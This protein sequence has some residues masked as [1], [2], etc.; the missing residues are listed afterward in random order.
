MNRPAIVKFFTLLKL[1]TGLPS[2]DHIFGR[3]WP[4]IPRSRQIFHAIAVFSGLDN[5]PATTKILPK[6]FLTSQN[7]QAFHE[8][9]Y[10][11]VNGRGENDKYKDR[12]KLQ[13]DF[14]GTGTG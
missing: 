4:S 7:S 1:S 11:D 3:I 8:M 2:K 12:V 9:A 10:F 5:F 6:K 14:P 13:Q